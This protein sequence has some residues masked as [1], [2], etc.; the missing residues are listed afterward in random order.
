M[1]LKNK[2]ILI[3]G[4]LKTSLTE[5]LEDFLISR[6]RTLGIIGI[7]SPFATVKESRCTLYID[8]NKVKEWLLPAFT[9]KK[10]TLWNYPLITISYIVFVYSFIRAFF[11][12]NRRFDIFIGISTFSAI[13]GILYKKVGR[14]KKMIY[15]CL[16]YYVT[17]KGFGFKKMLNLLFMILEPWAL[18]NADFVWNLSSRIKDAHIKYF[19]LK[20]DKY[21]Q[22]IVPVSYRKSFSHNLPFK[23]RERWTLGFVGSL[24]ENQGL[25]LVVSAMPELIKI[26]PLIKVKVIGHGLYAE[27]IKA[28]IREKNLEDRFIFYGF[29]SDEKEVNNI[30]SQCMLGLAPYTGEFMDNSLFTEPGKPKLYLMLGLPVIVTDSISIADLIEINKAGEKIKYSEKELISSIKEIIEDEKIFEGYIRGVERIKPY[31]CSEDV[32][33]EAFFQ[34]SHFLEGMK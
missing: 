6:V 11:Y 3:A 24:S 8:G 5:N 30:L 23:K 13:F 7:A 9:I 32:Y 2:D 4:Q 17:P 19:G 1:N 16:D 33:S 25:Q 20:P 26:Y 28:M 10:I 22:T 34:S 12:L 29:I 27:E 18:K 15:Y 31:C 21:L 14:V